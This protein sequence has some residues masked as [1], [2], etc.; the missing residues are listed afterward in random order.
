MAACGFTHEQIAKCLGAYGIDPKTLRRHFN[1]ELETAA[2]MANA[3]IGN[4]AFQRAQAGE[5]WA[6][7]FWM[8]CRAGWKDVTS[9]DHSGS[10]KTI[11]LADIDRDIEEANASNPG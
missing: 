6:V 4:V 11:T 1:R 9:I 3:T 2:L 10:I 8:K 7:C 5:A